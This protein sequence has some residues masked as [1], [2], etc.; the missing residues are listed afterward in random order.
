MCVFF[1]FVGFDDES[2][3]GAV[4]VVVVIAD[5]ELTELL[6]NQKHCLKNFA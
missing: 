2:M 6:Q 3:G 4:V 1:Y 5:G